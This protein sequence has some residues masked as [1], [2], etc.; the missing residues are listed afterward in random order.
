M[1]VNKASGEKEKIARP[2]IVHRLDKETSGAMIIVKNQKTF[3][4]LKNQ[5]KNHQIQKIYQ[6]FVYGYV[7]EPAASLASGKHGVINTPIGRSPTD[8][9][10]WTAGRG[11]R[12]PRREAV[13]E[14]KV[15]KRFHLTPLPPQDFSYLELYPKTGRTH[16]I[17]VHLRYI[18]H[19]IVSDW[20]YAGN[21][22]KTLGFG[23][24]A[25]HARSITFFLPNGQKKTI[26]AP[27][28]EDF[29][30]AMKKYL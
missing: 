6:A 2:G 25:L 28:P 7:K 24:T 22:E 27:Y 5:F 8:I 10:R 23:R 1:V 11:A 26:E 20:L 12:E 21:K 17:R 15:L 30:K 14:Y 18:N 16:Q 19:P 29:Q 4:F 3:L 13:T 9:R